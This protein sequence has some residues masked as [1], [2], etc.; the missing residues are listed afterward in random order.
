MLKH[1]AILKKC[2]RDSRFSTLLDA[3]ALPRNPSPFIPLPV[4]RQAGRGEGNNLLVLLPRVALPAVRDLP[5]AATIISLLRSFSLTRCASIRTNVEGGDA[6]ERGQA[7]AGSGIWDFRFQRTEGTERTDGRHG[8]NGKN[9]S[10]GLAVRS[11]LDGSWIL[12]PCQP[13]VR[14]GARPF[15]AEASA[16]QLSVSDRSMPFD[17]SHIAAAWKGRAPPR[18]QYPDAHPL[19]R[20]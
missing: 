10:A 5:W 9:G 20:L 17:G 6:G 4:S 15:Q 12:P 7:G 16:E 1:W 2:L 18:G 11:P 3:S 19:D 8:K 13:P 14:P